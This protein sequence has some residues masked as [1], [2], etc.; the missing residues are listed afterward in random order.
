MHASALCTWQQEAYQ[1]VV[2]AKK[3]Q[4]LGHALLITGLHGIGQSQVAQEVALFLVTEGLDAGWTERAQRQAAAQSNPDLLTISRIPTAAG[5][6]LRQ[7]IT[8]EQIRELRQCLALTAHYG[9]TR[10]AVIDPA[11]A[12]NIAANNALLKTLEE[13]L[14]N[15]Y[16]CLVT[17]LPSR[18]P[19]TIRSRCQRFDVHPPSQEVA[20]NWLQEQG[21]DAMIA[22]NALDAA[23]GHPMR[24]YAYLQS[25]GVELRKSV[26]DALHQLARGGLYAGD[27]VAKW[28]DNLD[29]RL[30]HAADFVRTL[31]EQYWSHSEYVLELSDWF[32]AVN[33][34]RANLTTSIR[35]DLGLLELFVAWQSMRHFF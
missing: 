33:A 3:A 35:V 11:D 28:E 10:V 7:E 15:R 6:K 26:F 27:L 23:C 12:M 20:L 1:N 22:R 25:N 5:D 2:L 16:I 32:D 29:Q 18:L 19:A 24:A 4:R 17:D 31:A 21:Y 34:L 9:D 8:V 30:I 13:P 14:P